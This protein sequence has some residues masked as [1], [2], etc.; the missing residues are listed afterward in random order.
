MPPVW[1]RREATVNNMNPYE[2]D[3]QR[4]WETYFPVALA[5]VTDPPSHFREI[6]E[7]TEQTIR[8]RADTLAGQAPVGETFD[9]ARARNTTARRQ[10]ESEVIRRLILIDP[11]D[12]PDVLETLLAELAD[13][14]EELAS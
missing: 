2:T 13:A 7:L 12:T 3:A 4:H 14:A 8:L 1:S 5:A 11:E 9:Q 6:G 10:A